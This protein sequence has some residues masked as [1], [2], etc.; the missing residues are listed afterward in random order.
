MLDHL[1]EVLDRRDEALHGGLLLFTERLVGPRAHGH[2]PVDAGKGRDAA[3]D[4]RHERRISALDLL[5]DPVQTLSVALPG[6]VE[7][8]LRL[9]DGE[10]LQRVRLLKP[11]R[12][13]IPLNSGLRICFQMA[14]Q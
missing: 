2:T 13:G 6:V 3:L 14:N 9:A 8:R 12:P 1:V 7:D 11:G 5:E 4:A 10:S